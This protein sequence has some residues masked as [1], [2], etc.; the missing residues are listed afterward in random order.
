MI[1]EDMHEAGKGVLLNSSFE[2]SEDI[3]QNRGL[4]PIL[5]WG[6][7]AVWLTR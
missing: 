3:Y 2:L 6:S 4:L 1:E 7:A 5:P